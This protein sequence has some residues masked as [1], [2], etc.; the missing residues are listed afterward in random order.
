MIFSQVCALSW[1]KV[2]QCFGRVFYHFTIFG[3]KNA[4]LNFLKKISVLSAVYIDFKY[5]LLQ[6]CLV[7]LKKHQTF[8]I[9]LMTDFFMIF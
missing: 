9:L 7:D 2:K 5:R 4:K 8:D 3:F 1:T 6:T